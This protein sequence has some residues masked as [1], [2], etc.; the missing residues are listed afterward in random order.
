MTVLTQVPVG[1]VHA[2]LQAA[3]E[4]VAAL[5]AVPVE[6]LD[7]AGAGELYARVHALADRVRAVGIRVLP[8]IE[9]HGWWA[10]DGHRTAAQWV[11][12]RTGVSV[13]T[14]RRDLHLGRTLH[15][16]LPATA[17]AVRA[18]DLALEQARV[19][20]TVAATSPARRAALV[21]PD[22]PCA[23][24]FLVHHARLL[25]VDPLRSLVRRWAAAADPDTDERGYRDATEREFLDVSRT[26]G[27]F[28]LA[29]F[30][31]EEHGTVLA[32]ALA[33]VS[34]P[35]APGDDRPSSARRAQSL[36]D[37]ARTVLDHGLARTAAAVRPHLNIQL[38]AQ[39]L[40]PTWTTALH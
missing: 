27:G 10:L 4:A 29:G 13:A 5:A 3:E 30:L 33:A 32:T 15:E 22:S 21:D 12:H 31:T 17:A 40:A 7:G 24:P 1:S 9:A 23:E 35:P 28:H 6:D 36:C 37:L 18:G 20:A 16:E 8:V 26:L 25:P 39:H 14:A 19:I 2:R 11:V 34:G 38:H